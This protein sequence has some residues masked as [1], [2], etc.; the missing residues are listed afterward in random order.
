MYLK[1]IIRGDDLH[2][3]RKI[4][5]FMR[6]YSIL[7]TTGFEDLLGYPD[8]GIIQKLEIVRR[9]LYRRSQRQGRKRRIQIPMILKMYQIVQA[10]LKE[11]DVQISETYE[12]SSDGGFMPRNILE[13]LR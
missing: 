6:L 12:D 1:Y 13:R 2:E 10:S 11:E 4:S 7:L 5:T 9:S 3:E 8:A